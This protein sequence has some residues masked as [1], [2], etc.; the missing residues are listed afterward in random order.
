M[1]S[2]RWAEIE[3]LYHGALAMEP[4]E[5]SR[6][7]EAACAEDPTL[8]KEVESL[9]AY[10]DASLAS[11]PSQWQLATLQ[12]HSPSS[13]TGAGASGQPG[14][15]APAAVGRYRIIRL[16]GEGG[17]GVVHEAEQEQ[18]RRIVALKVIKPGLAGPELLR[19][20]EQESQALA[21]LQHPGIAQVYEAG[22]A[23]SGFGPQP[24][25][26]ME[27]IRGPSLRE[28]AQV[29]DLNVR[30][31]LELMIKI[32]DAVHH[33]HQRGVIHRDLKP[34]NILVD[35]AG[36]P[37]VLDFGVARSTDSDTHATRQTDF[38]QLVG[39]LAY[40]SPEQVLGDPLELDTRSDVYALGVILY[41]LLAG[42]LPYQ[43]SQKL[44]EA[45]QTIRE[46]DPERLSSISRV[47]RG[48]VE[49]IVAK[50][51]EKDKARRYASAAGLAAD[52]RHYLQDEPIVAR[53]ASTGYQLSKF[54]RRHKAL[55]AGVTAV[56][57]VLIGGVAAS[58]WQAAR[59]TEAQHRALL[60]RDRAATA[61][62]RATDERDRALNAE[63]TATAAEAQALQDRNK[64]LEEK[65]RADTEAAVAKAVNDFLQNDLLAQASPASQGRPDKAPDA[66]LKVRTALDR[67]AARLPGRFTTQPLVEASIRQTIGEA[68]GDLGLWEEAQKQ[69]QRAV[70][71]RRQVLGERDPRTLQS[72]HWLA[73]E[74]RNHGKYVQ[75]EALWREVLDAQRHLLGENHRDT[76]SSMNGLARAY[77]GQGKYEPARLL[78]ERTVSGQRRAL[79]EDQADTLNSLN[80]LAVVLRL[81]GKYAEAE[82]LLTEVLKVKRRVLGAEHP[83]TLTSMNDLGIVYGLEGK[84]PKAEAL[85]IEVMNARIRMLGEM[86]PETLTDIS[87]VGELYRIEGKYAQAEPLLVKALEGRQRIL[88]EEHPQTLTTM[89]HLAH[90]YAGEGK[91]EQAEALYNTALKSRLEVSGP[92]HPDTL[93]A[94]HNLAELLRKEVKYA[95][96]EVLFNKALEG[97]RRVLGP[98]N[99]ATTNT[100]ASLGE[101]RL[102]QRQYSEAEALL[103]DALSG[104][105]KKDRENWKRYNYQI[106]LGASLVGQGEYDE[107]EPLLLSGYQGLIERTATIPWESRS[108]VDHAAARI[109]H[110]YQAW[111][112]PDQAADWRNRLPRP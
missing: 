27:L 51:L 21:R 18:P 56:F 111:G 103:R 60:E 26:A 71:L 109:V 43:I 35:A 66:E 10:A 88:G 91:Y 40:M 65:R 13:H 23:D 22:T 50:A 42:R 38:G 11:P 72:M 39:T 45:V 4:A 68:Y 30:Q 2:Q 70:T 54:V 5:R 1:D 55:G 95:E 79:G 81:E 101:L 8:R 80:E 62:Q 63:R 25:F 7:L 89:D 33:A 100:V 77:M 85:L 44:H 58:T 86:R 3:P 53:P 48:D 41:E 102:Q 90:L 74:Y 99:P 59:A 46:E 76:L 6:Y 98:D 110:L 112:K 28:Y 104:Q 16:L 92:Q 106:L 107:A 83:F 19:R 73:G 67:A 78:L 36:Q 32:C 61:E 84:Y 69:I 15:A 57:V 87:N 24:Y 12:D 64:V 96:A 94:M 17:M 34:G 52:I 20:F 29:L 49:T 105:E 9:L 82:P 14:H 97:E 31:R 108:A 75:A 37:K 47:Y 93:G